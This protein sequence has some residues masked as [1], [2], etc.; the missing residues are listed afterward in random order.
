MLY[1]HRDITSNFFITELAADVA[2]NYEGNTSLNFC[3]HKCHDKN[4]YY[5]LI[6]SI[7]NCEQ[8]VQDFKELILPK[9]QNI[10]FA[11]VENTIAPVPYNNQFN[12]WFDLTEDELLY[13]KMKYEN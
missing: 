6:C 10:K 2:N 3:L 7:S 9:L 4:Y 8:I 12:I 1:T 5:S 13:W 11:N